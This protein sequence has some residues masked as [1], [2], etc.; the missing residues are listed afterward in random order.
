MVILE[1]YPFIL[2][3]LFSLSFN[4]R[5]YHNFPC[6]FCYSHPQIDFHQQT[7]SPKY[8]RISLKSIF[9]SLGNN[10]LCKFSVH[11]PR[12]DG[13]LVCK[14]AR[15]KN[16]LALTHAYRVLLLT[17]Y[18]IVPWTTIFVHS[19]QYIVVVL[20]ACLSIKMQSQGATDFGSHFR[21]YL[22]SRHANIMLCT[23]QQYYIVFGCL[24]YISMQFR[25]IEGSEIIVLIH[26]L[27]NSKFYACFFMT[28]FFSGSF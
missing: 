1:K 24:L 21:F 7:E 9:L 23:S 8:S 19:M 17:Q 6:L 26:S 27:F 18:V 12:C 28:L 15:E 25:R 11:G 13:N 5:I 16:A 22:I 20:L 3:F 4:S 14:C 2:L 10:T